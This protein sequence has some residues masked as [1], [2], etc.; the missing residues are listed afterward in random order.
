MISHDST[1]KVNNY[2]RAPTRKIQ[3]TPSF[4]PI[5]AMETPPEG[6]TVRGASSDEEERRRVSMEGVAEIRR[7]SAA[8][9]EFR[10]TAGARL[11]AEWRKHRERPRDIRTATTLTVPEGHHRR[12][13]VERG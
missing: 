5:T 9:Y 10:M 8:E 1:D 3:P 4:L 12:S 13:D 2:R 11:K 6:D 7:R